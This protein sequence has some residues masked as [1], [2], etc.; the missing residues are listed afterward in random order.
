MG[1]SE[2]LVKN[3]KAAN[4]TQEDLAEKCNVS[5]Q[6]IAKWEKAESLPDVY[7][8]A[9]LA[10]LFN[11][12]IEE[13]IW[14]KDEAIV[15]NKAYYLRNIEET[16]KKTFL[17]LLREHRLFGG[18]LKSLDTFDNNNS[19]DML[20]E[21]Y[22]EEGKTYMVCT[23]EKQEEVGYF[24]VE[25]AESSS[26]QMTIQFKGEEEFNEYMVDLVKGFANML[27]REY[28]IRAI[29]VFV[30]SDLERKIFEALG[31]E[32]VSEEVIIVL[33]V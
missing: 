4:L 26:P 1:F 28:R 2:E 17:R 29:Q 27:N 7:T 9:K 23:K 8:I 5:R 11:I 20:W 25:A 16:D 6:A 12:S 13:L 31:Y 14:S 32:K 3:R 30:N 15:E 33:P 24:Y 18:L 19:D 10:S 22:T 21:T